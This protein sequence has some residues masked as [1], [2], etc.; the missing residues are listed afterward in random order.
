MR[1][2]RAAGVA[3]LVCALTVTTGCTSMH[4]APVVAAAREP[5]SWRVS[6]GDEVRVTTRD[7]RRA[8]FTVQAVDTAGIIARDGPR[9]ELTDIV[10]LERRQFS[11]VKTGLLGL[12]IGVGALLFLVAAAQATVGL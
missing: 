5:S 10:A 7:G 4:R 3:L 8:Q 2:V 12:G 11:G 6:P 1:V 9:F